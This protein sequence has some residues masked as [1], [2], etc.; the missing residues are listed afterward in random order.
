VATTFDEFGDAPQLDGLEVGHLGTSAAAPH[1][2]GGN[3]D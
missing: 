3:N 1:K 2:Q